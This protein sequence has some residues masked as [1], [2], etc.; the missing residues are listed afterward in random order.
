MK[1]RNILLIMFLLILTIFLVGCTK[2]LSPEEEIIVDEEGLNP[3]ET[4]N[5]VGEASRT[6]RSKFTWIHC[7]DQG[8]QIIAG[9]AYKGKK[10]KRIFK[11]GCIQNQV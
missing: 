11:N 5:F 3:E 6:A 10:N 8:N 7:D 2:E 1:K 9:Y 4:K